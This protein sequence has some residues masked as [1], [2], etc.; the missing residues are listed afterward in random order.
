MHSEII[1]ALTQL[2]KNNPLTAQTLLAEYLI[3]HP[4]DLAGWMC[5]YSTL[6]LQDEKQ[7]CLQNI[8]RLDPGNEHAVAEL[9]KIQENQYNYADFSILKDALAPIIV[10]SVTKSSEK[11][12]NRPVINDFSEDIYSGQKNTD[13][14]TEKSAQESKIKSE[15]KKHY[16]ESKPIIQSESLVTPRGNISNG[17]HIADGSKII[18]KARPPKIINNST[19]I[20]MFAPG[21]NGLTNFIDVDS[22]MYGSNLVTRGIVIRL[23]EYPQCMENQRAGYNRCDDCTFFPNEDCPI[24]NNLD[25]LNDVSTWF[26]NQERRLHDA[27]ERRQNVIDN[28]YNELMSHGRPLH[29]EVLAKI[30]NDRYPQLQLNVTVV[31]SGAES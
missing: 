29:Y 15:K 31:Q 10:S 20:N 23:S 28:I 5:L 1:R 11:P 2:K 14:F 18:I 30:I 17:Y 22:G 21:K 24:R 16:K 26:N 25:L 27:Q 19:I 7:Y 8:L 12:N 13:T 3:N 4:K 9:R 6:F